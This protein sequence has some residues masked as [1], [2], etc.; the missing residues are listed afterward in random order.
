MRDECLRHVS[1][2]THHPARDF[3]MKPILSLPILALFFMAGCC[4]CHP[5]N[6]TLKQQP[7][8]GPTDSMAKVVAD[9]NANNS[10]IPTLWAH[11]YYEADVVDDK[12]HSH[13]VAGDG[14]LLYQSPISMRLRATA[15]AVGTVF[16]IGSNPQSFWFEL[17]P[18]TGS[19]LWWGNYADLAKI[20][21]DSAGIPIRPDMVRDVLGIAT[22]NTNFSELP[23]PTMRFNAEADAYVFI[24]IAKRIDR[25]IA[26]REVWYDRVTKRPKLVLLYDS[27]GRVVLRTTFDPK[28]YRQVQVP[29]LPR[30]QWPW[31]PSDYKLSYPDTGSMLRITLDQA[32][33]TQNVGDGVI[34]PNP[35]SFR[36]PNPE[37]AGVD[38]VVRIAEPAP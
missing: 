1:V 4:P 31:M 30:E 10:K 32:Q 17:G 5:K 19:T 21:P 37:N 34:V 28:Q 8:L 15:T 18:D 2:I 33:L 12:K 16:E 23:A 22:I 24:W 9:I 29:D 26:L 36:M 25:W 6:E 13:H 3:Q 14:V 7:W 38:K 11:H 20:D 27:N 35:K